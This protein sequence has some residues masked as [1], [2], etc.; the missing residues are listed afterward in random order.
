MNIEVFHFEDK[1]IFKIA[2]RK[3]NLPSSNDSYSHITIK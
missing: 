2:K 1:T 3:L